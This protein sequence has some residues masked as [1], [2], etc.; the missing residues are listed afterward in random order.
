MRMTAG[1]WK[2]ALIAACVAYMNMY[3]MFLLYCS[4][5]FQLNYYCKH[6]TDF[7][8][9]FCIVSYNTLTK[10]MDPNW[11][12]KVISPDIILERL[13]LNSRSCSM[14]SFFVSS[15]SLGSRSPLIVEETQQFI[16]SPILSGEL[17]VVGDMQSHQIN[18]PPYSQIMEFFR[19][20]KFRRM[21]NFYVSWCM[22]S[23]GWTPPRSI[24]KVC[25]E[26]S[27]M[28]YANI[29]LQVVLTW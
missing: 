23:G 19:Q 6:Q 18:R 24:F 17:E 14:V 27:P 5:V 11:S 4:N 10:C 8:R 2:A 12:T 1:V 9:I 26:W 16:C 25:G 22:G 20:S 28:L 7:S 21:H 29:C 3:T 13:S 15:Y